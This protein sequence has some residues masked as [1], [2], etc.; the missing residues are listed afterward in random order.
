MQGCSNIIA[1]E[2]PVS[3]YPT[4]LIHAGPGLRAID[5]TEHDSVSGKHP[6]F[7]VTNRNVNPHF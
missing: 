4:L 3:S 7:S 1:Q 5:S 6:D 2:G